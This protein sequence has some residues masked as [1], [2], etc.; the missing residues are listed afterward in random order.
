MILLADFGNTRVKMAVPLDGGMQIV[1]SGPVILDDMIESV[2]QYDVKGGMW[3]AVCPVPDEVTEWM[4]G[5]GMLRLTHNTAVPISNAYHTP[6]TLGMDRL[7]A[8]VGAWSIKPGHNLLVVDAGTAITMD[9]VSSKGVYMGGNIAP[10]INL[11]LKALHEY[12]GALP[13]V[14]AD[15]DTPAFGYNT[16]TAIRS[17]VVMG[18]KNELLGYIETLEPEYPSLLV[19]LTG[20]DA[21]FFDIRGKKPIFAVWDLVFRGMVSILE[22]NGKSY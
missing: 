17:G 1:Y 16:E 8:A 7:A 18:I 10:G 2:A 9:F 15:G 22:Y 6:H 4:E 5:L 13:L 3:C 19:F 20:G 11:R 14:A 12:T 21:D